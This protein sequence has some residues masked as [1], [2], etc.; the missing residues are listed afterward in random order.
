MSGNTIRRLSGSE[1]PTERLAN[2]SLWYW[3]QGYYILAICTI[4][5]PLP[6]LVRTILVAPLF[7]LFPMGLGLWLVP[8]R[9]QMAKMHLRRADILGAA[10]FI[11]VLLLTVIFI[12]RE[13]GIFPYGEIDVWIVGCFILSGLGF[14]YQRQAVEV[15]KIGREYL[16][17]LLI[18][19]SVFAIPYLVHFGIY[20]AYPYTDLFQFTHIMKGAE[21]FAR[22]DR[23]NPFNADSYIPVLQV[24]AG[25]LIRF[26]GLN[27]LDGFWILPVVAL[28]L[29][30]LIYFALAE[31]LFTDRWGRYLFV[32][33]LTATLQEPLIP[34]NGDLTALGALLVLGMMLPP[35]GKTSMRG[36]HW[37]LIWLIVVPA[38]LVATW[39]ARINAIA[40]SVVLLVLGFVVLSLGG[41]W[42]AWGRIV[43]VVQVS[44]ALT[45]ISRGSWLF[46]PVAAVSALWLQLAK[47]WPRS[48]D[49]VAVLGTIFLAITVI[50]IFLIWFWVKPEAKDWF[51]LGPV[52]KQFTGM[53]FAHNMDVSMGLG[54]KV[55]LFEL[56][57]S[58]GGWLALGS[59]TGLVLVCVRRRSLLT[60]EG[61]RLTDEIHT[62]WALS[63]VIAFAM[64]LGLPFTYRAEFFVIIFLT[65]IW[66]LALTKVP[67]SRIWAAMASVYLS[68]TAV[69]EYGISH[70]TVAESYISR[71]QPFALIL[72]FL[73]IVIALQLLK[74][75][76]DGTV[77]LSVLVL[78]VLMWDR[79]VT[80]AQ[81]MDYA[82]AA[83][84]PAKADAVSHY[85]P[86]DLEIASWIRASKWRGILVSDPHTIAIVGALTGL[87]GVVTFS[88]LGTMPTAV[89]L[90]LKTLLRGYLD[91]AVKSE[92]M[93]KQCNLG[94]DVLKFMAEYG[95]SSG[96]NYELFR[97]SHPNLTGGEVLSIFGYRSGI[98][99]SPV[100][101]KSRNSSKIM[102]A[103]FFGHDDLGFNQRVPNN[104]WIT[105]RKVSATT[106]RKGGVI[107]IITEKT[108]T[109]A[110]SKGV[111]PPG[112]FETGKPLNPTLVRNLVS[113]CGAIDF[114]GHAL[115]ISPSDYPSIVTR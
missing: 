39:L 64:L 83:P 113:Q 34:T 31:R 20:S 60:T 90:R 105:T 1:L 106:Q 77:G 45:P 53:S 114:D 17:C 32:A 58:V 109:W 93:R 62:Y 59:L 88:N 18:A 115:V 36:E 104:L 63:M 43:L 87:N 54:S 66:V 67:A 6:Q 46:L 71:L 29:R 23:L 25:V 76:K 91:M 41:R 44:M 61:R 12:A 99:L 37:S 4:F 72:L 108:Y 74:S 65:A 48:R 3:F 14:V 47:Q 94:P 95:S 102:D 68:T 70:N 50:T 85:G 26:F 40:L 51:W 89:T 24:S 15:T 5:L 52:V 69:V 9:G 92:P 22:F 101:A 49:A 100:E 107:T 33:I 27:F 110:Y 30:T 7:Y 97:I 78:G 112:Y 73:L 10:Y 55:A 84:M 75:T 2:I 11:G 86:S 57:R 21:E 38:V 35:A 8:N 98:V 19:S 111:S 80:F 81:F 96:A 79:Q 42:P 103:R 56:A 13:R 82:Y 16:R 28:V